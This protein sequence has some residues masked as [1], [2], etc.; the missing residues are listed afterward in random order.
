MNRSLSVDEGSKPK[1]E[2]EESPRLPAER[3]L[4]GEKFC[5]LG[6][7]Q[8]PAFAGRLGKEGIADESTRGAPGPEMHWNRESHLVLPVQDHRRNA[9]VYRPLHDVLHLATLEL[10][11]W[12]HTPDQVDDPVVEQ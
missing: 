6:R 1:F 8:D 12:R 11:S 4:V 9:V 2:T 3:L 5:N 7:N 10:Q